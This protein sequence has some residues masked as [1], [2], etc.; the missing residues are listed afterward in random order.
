MRSF[1][2]GMYDDNF[3]FNNPVDYAPNLSDQWTL[4]NLASCDIHLATGHGPW[5]NSGPTRRLASILTNKG[6]P[7][8]LDDWGE[9]GGHDWPYWKHQ[10]R[11]Y[12]QRLF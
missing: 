10:M 6:I 1:M 2:N 4:T 11:E 12:I 3:Y 5:E 8:H 9:Q 7:N